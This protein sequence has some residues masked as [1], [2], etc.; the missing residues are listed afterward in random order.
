MTHIGPHPT[1]EMYRS[2]DEIDC[3]CARCGS[4]IG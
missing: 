2:G 1:R 3:Q 4:S